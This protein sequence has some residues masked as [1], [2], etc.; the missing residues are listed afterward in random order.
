[1]VQIRTFLIYVVLSGLL[2]FIPTKNWGK[3]LSDGSRKSTLS[4]W[5]Y[6]QKRVVTTVYLNLMM[7]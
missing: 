7:R 4:F 5:E 2:V 1:M 3:S 6:Q